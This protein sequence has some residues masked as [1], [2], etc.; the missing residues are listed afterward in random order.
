MA[1]DNLNI[2]ELTPNQTAKTQTINDALQK[3][4]V[5]TQDGLAVA[6]TANARTLTGDEFT[7]HFEFVAGALTGNGTLT[8]PLTK[9]FFAVDNSGSGH[10]LT[11]KGATG[12]AVVIASGNRSLVKCDGT[13]C[14]VYAS[15]GAVTAAD[16]AAMDF[17]ILSTSNPGGGK[18]WLNGTG[19][20]PVGGALWVGAA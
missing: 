12:A 19:G 18:L 5:A 7:S 8:V 1:T 20:S 13:D 17:S 14:K 11:V 3:L 10:Q 16:I 6:F 15:T 2:T 4:D 9:R